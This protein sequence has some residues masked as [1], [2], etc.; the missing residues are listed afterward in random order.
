MIYATDRSEAPVV[1]LFLLTARRSML[2]LT[3]LLAL[4]LFFSSV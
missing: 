1:V 4:R 3:L 2:R